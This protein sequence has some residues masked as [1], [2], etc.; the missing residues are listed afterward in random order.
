MI[1]ESLNLKLLGV[2]IDS[3]LTSNHTVLHVSN[4]IEMTEHYHLL[5]CSNFSTYRSVLFDDLHSLNL[6]IL[7][8]NASTL[9]RILLN[10]DPDIEDDRPRI[11]LET[12]I[13]YIL[14]TSRFS[15]SL[16]DTAP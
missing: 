15:G 1:W 7:P 8:V 13:K 14:S 5:R 12:V 11:V 16:F 4:S 2:N 10:G 6:C 9:S 3:N